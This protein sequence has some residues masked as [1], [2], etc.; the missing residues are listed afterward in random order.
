MPFGEADPVLTA[1]PASLALSNDQG[2]RQP[3]YRDMVMAGVEPD[4]VQ[5]IRRHLQCQHAYGGDRFKESIEA[6]LG[7]TVGPQKIGRPRKEDA[8]RIRRAEPRQL[9]I[10]EI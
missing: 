8:A 6:Q 3:T 1:H 10:I 7:R 9:T 2:T 5:S 4:D